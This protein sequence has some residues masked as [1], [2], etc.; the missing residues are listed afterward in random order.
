VAVADVAGTIP[1][2]F[3]EKNQVV[4]TA[5]VVARAEDT[6]PQSFAR[7]H[8]AADV[9]VAETFD[10]GALR[11]HPSGPSATT[12]T[13]TF[14]VHDYAWDVAGQAFGNGRHHTSASSFL[15]AQSS[16]VVLFDG[17]GV[18]SARAWAPKDIGSTLPG[19]FA[20]EWASVIL[21]EPVVAVNFHLEVLSALSHSPT[22]FALCGSADGGHLWELVEDFA[23]AAFLTKTFTLARP[24]AKF[25][26]FALVIPGAVVGTAS[27]V[28][29]SLWRI[30]GATPTPAA[31]L[32]GALL[33]YAAPADRWEPTTT[34][35]A[36]VATYD[37]TGTTLAAA[38]AQAALTEIDGKL[39]KKTLDAVV[40]PG[41]TNDGTEGYAV[42]SVW[43]D[44]A[45]DRSWTCVDVTTNNAVWRDTTKSTFADLDDSVVT[46]RSNTY[47]TTFD[48]TYGIANHF[49]GTAI[50][51]TTVW[52]DTGG[53]ALNTPHSIGSRSVS[54]MGTTAR[55]AMH[56]AL[57]TS[58]LAFNVDPT[59]WAGD[60][61]LQIAW[62]DFAFSQVAA[63]LITIAAPSD[64]M[65]YPA[66]QFM[67][68]QDFGANGLT[69]NTNNRV[70]QPIFWP[71]AGSDMMLPGIK[72]MTW[73][74]IDGELALYITDDQFITRRYGQQPF[75][76]SD[77]GA[78]SVIYLGNMWKN[79]NTYGVTFKLGSLSLTPAGLSSAQVRESAN[80]MHMWFA[81]DGF[82]PTEIIGYDTS[83]NRWVNK[84]MTVENISG[85]IAFS[86]G[87]A[88]AI[89]TNSS[90]L[91]LA[92]AMR[93]SNSVA[94]ARLGDVDVGRGW[95][96]ATL[97]KIPSQTN[98]YSVKA[99]STGTPPGYSI[100]YDRPPQQYSW[101]V[102]GQA[103]GNGLYTCKAYFSSNSGGLFI[104][105]HAFNGLVDTAIDA[106]GYRSYNL[107][108]SFEGLTGA[109]IWLLVPEAIRL[110][111]FQ[112]ASR[113]TNDAPQTFTLLSTT[114]GGTS[115]AV[116]EFFSGHGSFTTLTTFTL[117]VPSRPANGF[118]L[119]VHTVFIGD[120]TNI[121]EWE[122][123]AAT[124]TVTAV[125][126]PGDVIVY[127]AGTTN[128]W[129]NAPAPSARVTTWPLAYS[130]TP[131]PV[132]GTA[133][134]VLTDTL[135]VGR[136]AV[137]GTLHL[138]YSVSDTT[139]PLRVLVVI[140]VGTAETVQRAAPVSP[141]GETLVEAVVCG[142]RVVDVVGAPATVTV[143]VAFDRYGA[144]AANAVTAF[145]VLAASMLT[146]TELL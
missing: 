87:Q 143:T 54:T 30:G 81:G 51:S 86:F 63:V 49:K 114:D 7:L 119:V 138:S 113:V 108:G 71:G 66:S 126:D 74:Q 120:Q 15:D 102:S 136:W 37:A 43:V 134:T 88:L 103:H 132:L 91:E 55:P 124:P 83:V 100:I 31:T 78:A 61:T 140:T 122:L 26:A 20:G 70:A 32:D 82:L 85:T 131:A 14:G 77:M 62:A 75:D 25:N 121:M 52:P 72:I 17:A 29:L 104:A 142:R 123:Y 19:G 92:E 96:L 12:F 145:S 67:Q 8:R 144:L 127:T 3:A 73:T 57:D 9:F 116:E 11:Q 50:A 111:N 65:F 35:E 115:W 90:T 128:A 80:D 137:D 79:I 22:A 47:A 2:S 21:P 95:D 53:H 24:S 68:I 28:R 48:A 69:T 98:T 133:Y 39:A 135:A 10:A 42:D 16:S 94:L 27:A 130:A 109:W 146:A 18:S 117:T 93:P 58:S 110:V 139:R 33:R 99:A 23:T 1:F 60:W 141:A 101:T 40:P 34:I 4:A 89:E 56:I 112:V 45:A 36:A 44:V 97:R 107:A 64:V 5:A 13:A 84:L 6:A 41:P 46:A 118:A 38:T 76:T 59:I 106:L 105:A 125:P 129:V